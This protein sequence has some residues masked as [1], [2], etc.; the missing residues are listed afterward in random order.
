MGNPTDPDWVDWVAARLGLSVPR[1]LDRAARDVRLCLNEGISERPHV[2][3]G[4]GCKTIWAGSMEDAVERLHRATE[5]ALLQT[6]TGSADRRGAFYARF[7]CS[8]TTQGATNGLDEITQLPNFEAFRTVLPVIATAG[9][10]TKSIHPVWDQPD[11][12]TPAIAALAILFDRMANPQSDSYLSMEV[13]RDSAALYGYRLVKLTAEG[14]DYAPDGSRVARA[15]AKKDWM[16]VS[17]VLSGAAMAFI[18]EQSFMQFAP[19]YLYALAEEKVPNG[20]Q[21]THPKMRTP[22]LKVALTEG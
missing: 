17:T 15:M 22:F 1:I 7:A 14:F 18:K 19:Y 20:G 9:D 6:V 21:I 12:I 3:S 11:F 13:A 2:L 8:L 5:Y 4:H 10:G 16:H